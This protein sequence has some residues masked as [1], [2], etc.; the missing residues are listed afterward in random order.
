[1]STDLL[2]AIIDLKEEASHRIAAELLGASTDPQTVLDIGLEAMAEIG[3]RFEEGEYYLVELLVAGDIM[4]DL[5]ALALPH[6]EAQEA[7]DDGQVVVLGTVAGDVHDIG[8]NIVRFMLEANGNTV[9]DVGVDTEPEAFVKAVLETGATVVGLSGLLTT[10]FGS[11]KD[12][13][14]AFERANLRDTVRLMIGGGSV[15]ERVREYAAADA[16]GGSAVDAVR[17]ASTWTEGER[18]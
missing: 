1:M 10:S 9:H 15:D 4:E 3:R 13:V 16:V 18:A 2:N 12:T 6:M 11:M 5:A 14:A 8:K 17:F 7:T